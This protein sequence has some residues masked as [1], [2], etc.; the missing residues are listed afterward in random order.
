MKH[1][2]KYSPQYHLPPEELLDWAKQ[3]RLLKAPIWCSVDLRDGNQALITPMQLEEKIQ[4]YEFLLEVG[5]KEIEVGF[6]AASETEFAFLRHIIDNDLIPDDVAIQVLTQSRAHII[7]RT[8]EAVR[9]AKRVIVH[10]Y[11]S[12]STIQREQVFR[13][14]EDQIIAIA[15][16][17]ANLF[18]EYAEKYPE[19]EFIFQ[20]SPES[21]T[22]T[23]PEFALKVCNTLID[24][25]QPQKG[26]GVIINL[27][28][29]VEHSMPHVYAQ[30]VAYM[31]KHLNQREHILISLH[32][33]NDRGTGVAAA[34]M[35]VL[36]GADRVEGTLFGNGE[37][38]GNVDLITLAGNLYTHGVDPGLDLS[39]MPRIVRM[40]EE[41]NKLSVPERH[42]YAG[43][44]A[45]AAFSGSHQDA[46]AK[47]MRFREDQDSDGWTVPYLP[48]DPRD[49][50]REYETDIIR[51]NSQSG[52]GG[53]SYILEQN[54]GYKLPMEFREELGYFVKDISDRLAK[55]LLP[56]EI[57]DA[58]TEEYVN[59]TAPVKILSVDW[60]RDGEDTIA[61]V[62]F[63]IDGQTQEESGQGNG[64]LDAVRAA[65]TKVQPDKNFK[66][67][68]Y[69]QH[70][71]EGDSDARAATY[72][73]I[74]SA[75]GTPVWGVGIHHDIATASVYAL[76]S[77]ANRLK[78]E[79]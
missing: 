26:R 32:P 63:E 44:L 71:L 37:R 67:E 42:P 52:K 30:Q 1:K 20:Y 76:L 73:K 43:S 25:W 40:H 3:D 78:E 18:N 27:P 9:G 13:K 50:S 36:A 62:S 70:A 7:E 53:V 45:F 31:H 55:E 49:V 29:T 11:N 5:F 28:A 35:G 77:A 41:I 48:I 34:E 17:G 39:D 54:F 8:F 74:S 69:V 6:P 21:F 4:Y 58:F 46:I 15:E 79:A 16:V 65:L 24:I 56:G 12:T 68:D 2:D 61:D 64:T 33:H 19:T 57:H 66:F 51:I 47:G 75:A 60:R 23:E 59:A 38:T 14:S 10:L 72:V 22:G